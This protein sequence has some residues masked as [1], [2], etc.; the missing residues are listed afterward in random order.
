M[1][2]VFSH[3]LRHSNITSDIVR[4]KLLIRPNFWQTSIPS[5]PEPVVNEDVEDISADE[6]AEKIDERFIL[7]EDPQPEQN[8]QSSLPVNPGD[9]V[10]ENQATLRDY[11]QS[12]EKGLDQATEEGRAI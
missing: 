4:V 9:L 5:T 11:H 6:E 7:D 10:V 1:L 8:I 12:K 2:A 3:W